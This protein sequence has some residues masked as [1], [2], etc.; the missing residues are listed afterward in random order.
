M[1]T[2][3]L[4]GGWSSP[5][6]TATRGDEERGDCL[7]GN[8]GEGRQGDGCHG[9]GGRRVSPRC[10][11][12]WQHTSFAIAT[13]GQEAAGWGGGRAASPP[14]GGEGIIAASGKLS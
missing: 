6:A 10:R 9:N 11:S 13:G 3:S 5:I 1:A 8:R 14:L 12:P 7:R 2:R 4:R